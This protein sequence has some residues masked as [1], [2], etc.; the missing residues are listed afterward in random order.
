MT[1]EEACEAARGHVAGIRLDHPDYRVGFAKGRVL[2][3]GWYFD[4]TIEPTR[5]IP[6]AEREQ[7]AGA[8]GFIVPSSAGPIHIV[9]WAEFSDRKLGQAPLAESILELVQRS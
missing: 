6:E 3:E 8:P 7:F 1:Y 4:Y 2:S 5:P 9:S